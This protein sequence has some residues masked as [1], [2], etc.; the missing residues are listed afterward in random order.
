MKY[1]ATVPSRVLFVAGMAAFLLASGVMVMD[2]FVR[3]SGRL[4]GGTAAALWSL[5]MLCW[6]AGLT[7]A[8]KSRLRW[9]AG[10]ATI[11]AAMLATD[12]GFA[13]LDSLLGGRGKLLGFGMLGMLVLGPAVAFCTFLLH[14][15]GPRLGMGLV[16]AGLIL[17]MPLGVI[18]A[19]ED[20]GYL[21]TALVAFGLTGGGA[22]VLLANAARLLTAAGAS[23][24][25]AAE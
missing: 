15:A 7:I 24:R 8:A 9:A 23:G 21:L 11:A 17:W 19:V 1:E 20:Y 25:D 16:A 3:F 14:G 22:A 18:T 10:V 4:V 2:G 13:F 5:S 6:L 12:F